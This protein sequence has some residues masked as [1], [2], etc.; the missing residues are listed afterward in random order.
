MTVGTQEVLLYYVS[1]FV[2][3]PIQT[4]H[5]FKLIENTL[6]LPIPNKS[7]TREKTQQEQQ[8]KTKNPPK[9]TNKNETNHSETGTNIHNFKW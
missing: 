4:P 1:A 7:Q 6:A 9:N 5:R 2:K 8:N 3:P